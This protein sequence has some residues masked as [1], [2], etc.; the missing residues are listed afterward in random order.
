MDDDVERIIAGLS[1]LEN[2]IERLEDLV[3]KVAVLERQDLNDRKAHARI[4]GRLATV[5]AAQRSIY[6]MEALEAQVHANT[7]AAARTAELAS[8]LTALEL[9]RSERAGLTRGAVVLWSVLTAAPGL[10]GLGLTI[11]RLTG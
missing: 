1:R 5:E 3:S 2:R 9:E 4:E 11:W 8:R 7:A 10:V 6:R